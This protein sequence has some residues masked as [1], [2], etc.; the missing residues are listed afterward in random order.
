MCGVDS[1]SSLQGESTFLLLPL[2]SISRTLNTWY[3]FIG[4]KHKH[5]LC[6]GPWG[7]GWELMAW[8]APCDCTSNLSE[9]IQSPHRPWHSPLIGCFPKPVQAA[10]GVNP[11]LSTPAAACGGF[12]TKANGTITSPGWPREY[13]PNKNC[14]WQLVAPPQHRITLQF[15]AFETEGNDVSKRLS[16][17]LLRQWVVMC[18]KSQI[19]N[20]E[21]EI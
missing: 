16:I 15:D 13:P 7:L 21:V 5:E 3:R 19:H 12:L 18:L 17:T 9:A 2:S 20:S 6:W 4:N 8:K 11:D 14:I 1:H 10:V